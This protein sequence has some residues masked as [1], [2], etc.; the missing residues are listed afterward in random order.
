MLRLSKARQQE[1]CRNVSQALQQHRTPST[2]HLTPQPIPR[3]TQQLQ[4]S[5]VPPHCAL[6]CS[7]GVPR[8]NSRLCS[9]VTT[10]M[11]TRG[12]SA[13]AVCCREESRSSDPD[14]AVLAV[15]AGSGR[16]MP[17]IVPTALCS[18]LGRVCAAHAGGWVCGWGRRQQFALF[19]PASSLPVLGFLWGGFT[20]V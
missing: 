13:G 5:A 14:R 20:W 3:P 8:C 2:V 18:V 15:Q 10:A 17:R 11:C 16:G 19:A 12:S 9:R 1:A 6:P 7:G 4:P